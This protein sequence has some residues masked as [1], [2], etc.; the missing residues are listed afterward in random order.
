M[1]STDYRKNNITQLLRTSRAHINGVNDLDRDQN[2]KHCWPDATDL[3]G[4]CWADIRVTPLTPAVHH[5]CI[6]STHAHTHRDTP[7]RQRC[8]QIY[9]S[10]GKLWCHTMSKGLRG[11][12]WKSV[13]V[14]ACVCVC[15]YTR[16]RKWV[17]SCSVRHVCCAT[18][19]RQTSCCCRPLALLTVKGINTHTCSNRRVI[20][21]TPTHPI[22]LEHTLSALSICIYIRDKY[23]DR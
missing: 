14:C 23:V 8:V 9:K 16:L 21:H 2:E 19:H 3:D 18:T 12:L 7:L 17:I 4:V 5:T 20:T 1:K 6:S 13:R 10:T 22:A 11:W 15:M